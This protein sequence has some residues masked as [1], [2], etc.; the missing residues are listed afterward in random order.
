MPHSKRVSTQTC[1]QPAP[2]LLFLLGA[3]TFRGSPAACRGMFE[4]ETLN[5][6]IEEDKTKLSWFIPEMSLEMNPMGSVRRRSWCCPALCE[7]CTMTPAHQDFIPYT[8]RCS[9]LTIFLFWV[10]I[11][12][13][14]HLLCVL[15]LK[16]I[17]H[18]L[19]RSRSKV[20]HTCQNPGLIIERAAVVFLFDEVQVSM[21]L[22]GLLCL[23]DVLNLFF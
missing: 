7:N 1:W 22:S 4:S 13:L 6:C 16:L 8:C 15:G 9:L 17:I 10:Q 18:N 20:C 3:C 12:K 5:H 14:K 11:S 19:M 2:F 21:L 23:D